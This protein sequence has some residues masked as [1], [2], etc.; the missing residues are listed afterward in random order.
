MTHLTLHLHGKNP[1]GYQYQRSR[2]PSFAASSR[3]SQLGG[4]RGYAA[5]N[6]RLKME[7]A[8]F[9]SP[10]ERLL[11]TRREVN[12]PFA[13][14]AR[15]PSRT[16]PKDVTQSTER[17]RFN[18]RS[19]ISA[20]DITSDSQKLFFASLVLFRAP[21]ESKRG[22]GKGDRNS[23]EA[24][25]WACFMYELSIVHSRLRRGAIGVRFHLFASEV[26]TPNLLSNYKAGTAASPPPYPAATLSN[27]VGE[28]LTA[29]PRTKR[30]LPFRGCVNR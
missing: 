16:S 21:P 13:C 10:P 11:S 18:Q 30:R 17:V 14:Q 27:P 3:A 24:H 6:V 23:A 12:K 8:T 25:T 7:F 20:A 28:I 22:S 2:N 4:A 26:A 29:R 5:E 9:R 15:S 19:H 1:S